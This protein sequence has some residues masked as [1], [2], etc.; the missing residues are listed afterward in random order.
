VTSFQLVIIVLTGFSAVFW[1]LQL[2]GAL[3][4]VKTMPLLEKFADKP[5]ENPPR[6]SVIIPACNEAK[7]IEK[8]LEKRL[9]DTYPD[10]E[11]IL[12]DDRSNDGTREILREIAKKDR[13]IKALYI[14][15]LP[16]G[17]LGKVY[18]LHTGVKHATGD[19]FLFSDADAHVKPGTLKRVIQYCQSEQLDHLAIVPGFLKG[20]FLADTAISVFL[21]ALVTWGRSWKI[22]DKDSSAF[23]GSGSFNLVR[24]A[25]FERTKGFEWLKL[26]I[27]DDLGLGDMVKKSGGRSEMINGRGFV[28]IQ[29]YPTFREMSTG[30]GRAM[31]AGIANFSLIKLLLFAIF[32]FILDMIPYIILIPMGIPLLPIIGAVIIV[33]ALLT[34]IIV[35]QFINRPLLPAFFLPLGNIIMFLVTIKAAVITSIKRGIT[36]RGTFYSIQTLK[37]GRKLTL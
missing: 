2:I 29:W 7:T 11:F 37:K 27:V 19:W 16:E 33:V 28:S 25:A 14:D 10:L 3:R 22:K 9:Q 4:T 15:E 24:R 6:V 23:G 18:A 8:A 36:W 13:R 12:I 30:L 1:L 17:W 20:T 34:N 35:S 32:A 5:L 31:W 21:K 26:E